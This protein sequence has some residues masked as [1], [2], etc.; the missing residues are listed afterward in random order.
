MLSQ[1][2]PLFGTTSVTKRE[3]KID[4]ERSRREEGGEAPSSPKLI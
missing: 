1:P 2:F 4:Y 3:A